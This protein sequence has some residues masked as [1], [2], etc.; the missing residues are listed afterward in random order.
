MLIV[1]PTFKRTESVQ[2]VLKSLLR[3]TLPPASEECRVAIVNNFP[4]NEQEINRIVMEIWHSSPQSLNWKLILIHR[5]K[6]LP[7]IDNWYG[8]IQSLAKE[9]EIFVLQGD[10]DLFTKWSLVARYNAFSNTDA[11]VLLTG[12]HSGLTFLEDEKLLHYPGPIPNKDIGSGHLVSIDF[13]NMEDYGPVFIGSQS[14]RYNQSF[15]NALDTVA[16]WTNQDLWIDHHHRTIMYAL[17]V[18]IASIHLGARV[19]GLDSYC[20]IRGT[21][22][23]EKLYT[24]F[25]SSREANSGYLSLVMLRVFENDDLWPSRNELARTITASE[26]S[27]ADW[28]LTN[29]LDARVD[30]HIQRK[31]LK[32]RPVKIGISNVVFGLR[33]ILQQHLRL[34][35][36]RLRLAILLHKGVYSAEEFIKALE[37]A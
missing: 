7:L 9:N 34:K 10:D 19:K 2:L 6:T 31:L 25:N 18:V 20:C 33:I 5:E 3:C 15:R 23:Q 21:S 36:I 26:Q 17:Y 35:Y 4:P 30:L 1:I 14:Y 13:T 12:T 37:R 27:A 28:L 22:M 24:P 16:K 8:A 11:D 29:Y 32:L